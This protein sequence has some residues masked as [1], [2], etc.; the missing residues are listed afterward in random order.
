MMTTD[1][2]KTLNS[3][4]FDENN[5]EHPAISPESWRSQ[6]EAM[7]TSAAPGNVYLVEEPGAPWLFLHATKGQICLT[8]ISDSP[9]FQLEVTETLLTPVPWHV[10][11]EP[12][13]HSKRR[14]TVSLPPSSKA[15]FFRLRQ[16]NQT[17]IP[18]ET[19]PTTGIGRIRTML[20]GWWSRESVLTPTA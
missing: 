6:P 15:R 18:V 3:F 12:P 13:I 7:E 19:C 17:S 16:I 20:N 14:F 8:W 2:I 11:Q 4:G 9:H 10:V 5:N 1:Q